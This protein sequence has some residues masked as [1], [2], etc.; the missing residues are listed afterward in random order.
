[1][2]VNKVNGVQKHETSFEELQIKNDELMAAY[3][4]EVGNINLIGSDRKKILSLPIYA[5]KRNQKPTPKLC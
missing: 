4:R 1:M 3:K 2:L 5:V